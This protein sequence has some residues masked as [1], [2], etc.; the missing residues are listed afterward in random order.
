MYNFNSEVSEVSK[1]YGENKKEMDICKTPS[2]NMLILKF[3][4]IY[5]CSIFF[6]KI[7]K[8]YNYLDIDESLSNSLPHVLALLI[9]SN[10][11]K[12]S[13]TTGCLTCRDGASVAKT[14]L[15]CILVPHFLFINSSSNQK[16]KYVDRN[17]C[18]ESI[19]IVLFLINLFSFIEADFLALAGSLPFTMW[20]MAFYLQDY[21]NNIINLKDYSNVVKADKT[22]NNNNLIGAAGDSANESDENEMDKLCDIDHLECEDDSSASEKST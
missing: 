21:E 14:I 10:S 19:I 1:F 12:G 6:I 22:S 16:K 7:L 4:I 20:I 15:M 8:E 2:L 5:V 3:I 13:A 11:C 9:L 18:K 17:Y